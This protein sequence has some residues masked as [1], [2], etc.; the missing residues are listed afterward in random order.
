MQLQPIVHVAPDGRT[1]K[2][3]WRVF[4][5]AAQEGKFH[6]WGMGIAEN[7]YVKDGAIWK[8]HRVHFYPTL[9][10]PFEEGWG[11]KI[12][13]ASSF[14][15]A[16]TPDRPA[17]ASLHH[18]GAAS[19]A[20]GAAVSFPAFHYANPANGASTLTHGAAA[21]A[22]AVASRLAPASDTASL[23][24]AIA[25]LDRR[26]GRLEDFAQ[27]ENLQMRYGYYLATLEWDRLANLF[28]SDGTIEIAL[29]GVYVGRANIRRSLNLYGE[30]GVH[31]GNLHN[32]MQYQP[33]IH[34]APDGKTARVRAR[35]LSMMGNYGKAGM[36]MG[37]I[38]ENQFVK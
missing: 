1:A 4:I 25:D 31:E 5:Q 15:P 38:Y 34:V 8:I 6:E 21:A 22:N 9:F 7:E 13:S 20:A 28:A 17:P 23:A 19:G 16:L 32:H 36:W 18:T 29:R 12:N 10:T 11:R 14:E 27:L 33:V 2:G 30:P 35:A 37:G 24:N 26:I 3:R